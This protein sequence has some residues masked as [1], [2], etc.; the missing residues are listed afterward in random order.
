MILSGVILITEKLLMIYSGYNGEYWKE[1]ISSLKQSWSNTSYRQV[2]FHEKKILLYTSQK[3]PLLFLSPQIFIY[4]SWIFFISI[5]FSLHSQCLSAHSGLWC[6]LMHEPFARIYYFD[7]CHWLQCILLL[8]PAS[9][10]SLF[11]WSSFPSFSLFAEFIVR[12][13][14][15][16]ISPKH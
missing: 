15:N 9:L 13:R 3:P 5:I 12:S 7:F 4:W 16:L 10:L 14:H 8:L 1:N 2:C 6:F 11:S